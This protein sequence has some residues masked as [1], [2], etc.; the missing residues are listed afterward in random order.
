MYGDFHS[1][2][3]KKVHA[4]TIFTPLQSCMSAAPRWLPELLVCRSRI[5][6][7]SFTLNNWFVMYRSHIMMQN[8]TKLPH[9]AN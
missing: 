5:A 2:S 9:G 1:G 4:N 6:R 7:V 3:E 8:E